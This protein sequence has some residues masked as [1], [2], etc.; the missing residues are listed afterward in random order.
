MI[1]GIEKEQMSLEIWSL[2]S[3]STSVAPESFCDQKKNSRKYCLQIF[4][5]KVGAV[6][7]NEYIRW[8]IK[9]SKDFER[10]IS[11]AEPAPFYNHCS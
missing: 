10:W 3:F 5:E 11:I 8:K 9:R 7:C 1:L 4:R 2:I 6:C